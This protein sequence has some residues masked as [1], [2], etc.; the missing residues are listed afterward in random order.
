MRNPLLMIKKKDQREL[1]FQRLKNSQQK[2][3]VNGLRVPVKLSAM[4]NL[5]RSRSKKLSKI[6]IVLSH[7]LLLKRN[8][9]YKKKKSLSSKL[10]S[11]LRSLNLWEDS[12]LQ[13]LIN[14]KP[15][16]QSK[17]SLSALGK[18]NHIHLSTA[19]FQDVMHW[20]VDSKVHSQNISTGITARSSL[21]TINSL[22][23]YSPAIWRT[24]S[25]VRVTW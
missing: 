4:S 1:V 9:N 17:I 13:S 3:V 16:K 18:K 22:S 24:V 14:L 12:K 21:S 5:R 23:T 8:R 6:A 20:R 15:S 7:N 11:N 25:S 10:K 19:Q 2:N